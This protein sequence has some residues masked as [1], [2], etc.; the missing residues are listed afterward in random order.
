MWQQFGPGGVGRTQAQRRAPTGI[1]GAI[2]GL[3]PANAS[4][5]VYTTQ[6]T[7]IADVANAVNALVSA[8][9][10]RYVD[11]VGIWLKAHG[12]EM[13]M[14]VVLVLILIIAAREFIIE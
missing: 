2:A 8:D 7:P 9:I 12:P 6:A 13:L 5:P 3:N 14:G 4:K 11:I 1:V 10:T